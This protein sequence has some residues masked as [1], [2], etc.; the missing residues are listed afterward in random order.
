MENRHDKLNDSKNLADLF[1]NLE[2]AEAD[3]PKNLAKL[4]GKPKSPENYLICKD[5]TVAE[6]DHSPLPEGT[7]IVKE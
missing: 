2:R 5:G 1:N 3:I 6:T 7:V 4:K